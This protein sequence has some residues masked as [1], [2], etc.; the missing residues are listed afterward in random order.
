MSETFNVDREPEP[1]DPEQEKRKIKY[2]DDFAKKHIAEMRV[3]FRGGKLWQRDGLRNVVE[4]SL[5]QGAAIEVLSEMLELPDE[6]KELLIKNSICHDWDKRLEK[7]ADDFTQEDK[8]KAMEFLKKEM[9]DSNLQAATKPDFAGQI[10]E[11]KKDGKEIPI[12]QLLM[13]YIDDITFGGQDKP[14]TIVPFEERL[15]DTYERYP[16][17]DDKHWDIESKAGH[18][19]ED[20]IFNLLKEKGVAIEK[21]EDLPMLVVGA[22]ESKYK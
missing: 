2:W 5:P 22:I 8:E 1:T 14:G 17:L 20:T 6:E 9:L 11:A 12:T 7:R 18:I 19:A 16:N 13:F 15:K 21:A 4:H 10:V 3:L